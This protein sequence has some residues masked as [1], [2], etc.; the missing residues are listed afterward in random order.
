M[1]FGC[2]DLQSDFPESAIQLDPVFRI[3]VGKPF[4]GVRT[5]RLTDNVTLPESDREVEIDRPSLRIE[6]DGS[7][8]VRLA[9]LTEQLHFVTTSVVRLQVQILECRTGRGFQCAASFDGPEPC[10][11][12]TAFAEGDLMAPSVV[13]SAKD[14]PHVPL[15]ENADFG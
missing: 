8:I 4:E 14:Q 15:L 3:A 5:E 9:R 7:G 2:D 13:R 10:R 11:P 12:R 6:E 1:A